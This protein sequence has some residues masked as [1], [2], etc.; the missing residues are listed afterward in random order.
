M[1]C[2]FDQ[3]GSPIAGVQ[4]SY[5]GGAQSMTMATDRVGVFRERGV[6]SE[7][8]LLLMGVGEKGYRP[9]SALIPPEAW[10]VEITLPKQPVNTED[11]RFPDKSHS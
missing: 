10:E 9:A 8:L 1:G 4:V 5:H 11:Q 2:I 7:K 6:P 3:D